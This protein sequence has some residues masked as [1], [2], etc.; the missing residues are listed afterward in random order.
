MEDFGPL[1]E[2]LLSLAEKAGALGVTWG[3]AI[4]KEKEYFALL[5][6]ES[7][8]VRLLSVY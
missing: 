2:K 6:W 5:G 4:E 7:V 8:E 1:A 3:R